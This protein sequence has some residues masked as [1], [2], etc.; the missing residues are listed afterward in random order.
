MGT[1]IRSVLIQINNIK[2]HF[3][4]GELE[5]LAHMQNMKVVQK[6]EVQDKKLPVGNIQKMTYFMLYLF[7][8]RILYF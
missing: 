8:C 3:L 2:S 5:I 7:F 1:L 4:S 6:E